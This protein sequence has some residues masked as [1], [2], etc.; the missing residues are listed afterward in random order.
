MLG[1]R[2]SKREERCEYAMINITDK[3]K[4]SGCKACANICPVGAISFD[5]DAEGVWYP[6]IDTEKCIQCGQCEK[7]CPFLDDNH[8]V[9]AG[10]RSF[11]TKF[12][13]AQLKNVDDLQFV[14]SGGAFQGFAAAIMNGFITSNGGIVYG[15]AQDDVDHIY[16]IRASNLSELERTR[17]SKYFQSDIGMC[18]S[19]AKQDLMDGK[20]VLFSG[21]GCQIAGLNCFLRKSYKNL[22]TCEVVCHGVPSRKI[23]KLYRK[24]KEEQEGKK[25]VDLVFRDKSKGWSNN[26]YKIT[27]DDGSVEYERSTVQLFHAGYLQGLFYR[28]SCGLCPFASLP[29]VADVTLADYW[30][31]KGSMNSQN[32]GVSLVAVNNQQG[33][34]LLQLSEENLNLETTSREAALHS[35]RHMDEHPVENPNRKAFIDKALCDGYYSATDKFI[36]KNDKSF[37]RRIKNKLKK[38][39]WG[40]K[41]WIQQ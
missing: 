23:W 35:C 20:T 25:I 6:N 17:R 18:Y 9:S 41:V 33:M 19:L 11:K 7:T 39:C 14:S 8:G 15:A 29:R 12:Y 40:D 30:Q 5:D 24:E 10:N 32:F 36:H 37:A 16:H 27:Y 21:T 13:S 22:Y 1:K 34:K 2:F 4:C 28:P 31:Y 3:S 38:L 26:Q